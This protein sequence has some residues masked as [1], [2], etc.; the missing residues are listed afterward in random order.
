MATLPAYNPEIPYLGLIPGGIRHGTMIRI[1]GN[2]PYGGTRFTINL[3]TGAAT[4]PR[5]DTALHLSFRPTEPVIVRNH[6]ENKVWGHEERFGGCPI[7]PG[8]PFEILIL[9]ESSAYKIAIN[10]AHFCH[11]NHR[12]STHRVLF[13][14]VEGDITV[15]SITTSSDM[16]SAPP[17]PVPPP[18]PV[19]PVHP[20]RPYQPHITY[21]GH[22]PHYPH[23]ASHP[24]HPHH[25][26]NPPH[27][28][29]YI[30]G[31]PPPPPYTPSP[32][33]PGAPYPGAYSYIHP[34]N[35]TA[36]PAY[37][38]HTDPN[39]LR[40]KKKNNAIKYAAAAAGIGGGIGLGAFALSRAFGGS[41]NGEDDGGDVAGDVGDMG[42]IG[43]F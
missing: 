12:V 6:W 36:P 18:M 28:P 38:L 30:P 9:V 27:V 10:G 16:P 3:Q 13:L 29:G 20:I 33:T 7:Y 26:H 31:P 11:F 24:H 35:E 32:Y 15:T 1:N 22:G 25:L 42:D 14:A 41:G 4:R 40:R 19:H 8:Q 23:Y 39:Y 37:S 2:T 43:D 5:D 17:V 34:R 21:P